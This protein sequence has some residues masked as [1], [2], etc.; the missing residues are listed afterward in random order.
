MRKLSFEAAKA[1]HRYAWIWE[2]L[3]E[4]PTFALRSMFGAK[5]VYLDG[6]I[7]ACF[8]TSE[9][10]W[11]GMLL[12]TERDYHPALMADFP[13]LTP[14][15]VLGKWLYLSDSK[16]RFDG[17]AEKIIRLA[18]KSDPRIGAVPKP[19]KRKPRAEAAMPG[20]KS[21]SKAAKRK[22]A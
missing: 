3:E 17:I 2:P 8:C 13:E 5:A 20:G 12:C 22:A 9:E 4:K 11:N 14:H 1:P 21:K 15:P 19:K 7:I 10:P 18:L 6:K 16:S